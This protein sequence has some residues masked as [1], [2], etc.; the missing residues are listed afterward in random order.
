[1]HCTRLECA[2]TL[3]GVKKLV[4]TIGDQRGVAR[5]TVAPLQRTAVPVLTTL[6]LLTTLATSAARPSHMDSNEGKVEMMSKV[7]EYLANI[8]HFLIKR[9]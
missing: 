6:A 4:G 2:I 5:H 9:F 7:Q 8:L 1:M 3:R